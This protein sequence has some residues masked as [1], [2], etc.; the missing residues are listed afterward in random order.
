MKQRYL[1]KAIVECVNDLYVL[2]KQVVIDNRLYRNHLWLSKYS[3]PDVE[4]RDKIQFTAEKSYYFSRQITKEGE[5]T[6]K[7]NSLVNIK[8]LKVIDKA[9]KK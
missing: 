5:T 6:I 1:V 4:K 7:K 3:F 2:L 8:N 9:N